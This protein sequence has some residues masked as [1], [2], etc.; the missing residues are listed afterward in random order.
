MNFVFSLLAFLCLQFLLEN[1]SL[2][3]CTERNNALLFMLEP[4]TQE[5][6]FL[7]QCWRKGWNGMEGGRGLTMDI[8]MKEA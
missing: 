2:L 1:S 3:C 4:E 8:K 7:C 5:Q 6:Q